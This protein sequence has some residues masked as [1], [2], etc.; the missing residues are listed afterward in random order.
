MQIKRTCDFP[1]ADLKQSPIVSIG[2][3]TMIWSPFTLVL[4]VY[5]NVH[6]MCISIIRTFFYCFFS[7]GVCNGIHYAHCV[8]GIRHNT[9]VVK[10]TIYLYCLCLYVRQMLFPVW[11]QTKAMIHSIDCLV[12]RRITMIKPL[13]QWRAKFFTKPIDEME[14]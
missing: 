8:C 12:Y 2:S 14:K 7:C 11:T 6:C 3:Q 4:F 10:L 5:F 9:F 1:I 13:K